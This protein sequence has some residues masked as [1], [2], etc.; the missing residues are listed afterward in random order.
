[1]IYKCKKISKF[2][3]KRI[4]TIKIIKKNIFSAKI[5][6]KSNEFLELKLAFKN[7]STL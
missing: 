2:F 7:Y 6:F 5:W 1:M 4:S 3:K